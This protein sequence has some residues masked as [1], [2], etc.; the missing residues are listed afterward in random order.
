[1]NNF[2]TQEFGHSKLNGYKI[3]KKLYFTT[4]KIF[5]DIN[6]LV[7]NIVLIYYLFVSPN[8]YIY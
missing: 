8:A 3:K 5:K 7:V 1:L 2:K 6:L 4:N